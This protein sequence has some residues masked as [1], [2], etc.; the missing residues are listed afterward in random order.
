MA[1]ASQD[2]C[3]KAM[4]QLGFDEDVM[5][6]QVSRLSTGERQRLAFIR[7]IVLE[8][9][10]L[11][12]DEPTSALDSF[13]A[14]QLEALIEEIRTTRGVAVVWV[15]HDSIQLARVASEVLRVE[16]HEIVPIVLS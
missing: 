6:W 1:A 9:E 10:V 14:G 13:Y 8:P 11:L 4:Q 7:A 2:V 16:K 3:K 12:L 5:N 15:S